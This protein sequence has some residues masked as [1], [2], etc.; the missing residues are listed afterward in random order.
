MP[1]IV[2]IRVRSIYYSFHIVVPTKDLKS[3]LSQVVW[4]YHIPSSTITAAI[5][6]IDLLCQL[7]Q[8]LRSDYFAIQN[9]L[10][11]LYFICLVNWNHFVVFV[12]QNGK[13]NGPLTNTTVEKNMFVSPVNVL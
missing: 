12:G 1:E 13:I 7:I 8:R 2:Y 10:P 3:L 11:L 6:T 5:I 4:H 9:F